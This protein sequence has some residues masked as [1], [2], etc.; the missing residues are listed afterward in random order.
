MIV[1]VVEDEPFTAMALEMELESGGHEVLGPAASVDE[2][3]ALVEAQLP[4]AALMDINLQGGGDAIML[5][6]CLMERGVPALFTSGQIA[7]ARANPDAACGLI[8]KPYDP[9][10]VMQA[11]VVLRELAAGRRPATLPR[12][13]ELFAGNRFNPTER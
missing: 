10:T 11:L 9:Q 13:L 8:A 1:L 4:D 12:R 3:V 2:A 6:R 5:A 7:I